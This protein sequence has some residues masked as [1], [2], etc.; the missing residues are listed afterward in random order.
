MKSKHLL[1]ELSLTPEMAS[2][3]HRQ[4]KKLY[5]HHMRTKTEKF[6]LSDKNYRVLKL[7][8]S[9]LEQPDLYGFSS[10]E[11]A[12][13]SRQELRVM[14]SMVE[15]SKRVL[16][17]SVIPG[18]VEKLPLL[19]SEKDRE[20]YREALNRAMRLLDQVYKPL[21]TLIGGRL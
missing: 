21:L 6:K 8:V 10:V 3:V 2:N 9:K 5:E 4:A 11:T 15:T 20:R 7:L 13:F 16:E 1:V 12:R 18:Y 19:S 14:Q 17:E